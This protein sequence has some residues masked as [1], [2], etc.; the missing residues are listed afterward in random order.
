MTRNVKKKLGID[1]AAVKLKQSNFQ[2]HNL[3]LKM[4]G[5]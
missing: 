4:H 1:L 5:M 2:P 3:N